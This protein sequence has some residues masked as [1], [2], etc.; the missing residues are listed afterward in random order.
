MFESLKFHKRGKALQA[1]EDRPVEDARYVVVDT[2]LT[3]LH[4][5]KDSI[6][7]IGALRM[8]GGRIYPGKTFYRLVNPETEFRAES[9]VIHGITPSDVREKPGIGAALS[10]FLGFC[11]DDIVVGHCIYIDLNFINREMKRLFKSPLRNPVLDTFSL[12]E[13]LR[14]KLASHKA[15]AVPLRERSLPGIADYF[16]IPVNGAHNALMDAFITA[17]LFQKF[18]PLLQ[19]AGIRSIGDLLRVGNPSKGGDR[20][21]S[22]GEAMSF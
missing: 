3:G 11:G 16:G 8:T 21:R 18:L 6:V 12:Y 22:A 10:E 13:W 19:D 4:E 5:K 9:V 2:E 20:F 7:S 1:A 14:K 17:Q 15:F